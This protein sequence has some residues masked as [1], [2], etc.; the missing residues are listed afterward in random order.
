MY[1]RYAEDK[2]LCPATKA[3]LGVCIRKLFS[4]ASQ[5]ARRSGFKVQEFSGIV[6]RP[7]TT[8]QQDTIIDI[9]LPDYCTATS[10][11]GTLSVSVPRNKLKSNYCI[12][13]NI[14]IHDYQN[15]EITYKDSVT[16]SVKIA[17]A[18][19][20]ISTDTYP[21]QLHMDALIQVVQVLPLCAGNPAVSADVNTKFET[22]QC[23]LTYGPSQN[24]ALFF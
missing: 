4:C 3:T 8:G 19:Y 12:Q 23:T 10:S 15:L 22:G 20:G 21:D 18:E 24:F 2:K 7:V 14:I 16:R 13:F 11:P 9:C 17:L 5:Q 1:T 6:L